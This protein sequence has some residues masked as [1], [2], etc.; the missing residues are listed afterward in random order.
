MLQNAP[1]SV[2]RF[3]QIL[4]KQAG[5]QE[6]GKHRSRKIGCPHDAGREKITGNQ[7]QTLTTSIAR[8]LVLRTNCRLLFADTQVIN[9]TEANQRQEAVEAEERAADRIPV[10]IMTPSLSREDRYCRLTESGRQQLLLSTHIRINKIQGY[11]NN[12]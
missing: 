6:D 12:C 8:R 3:H 4:R 11:R 1:F 10:T 9:D 7:R 5:P 2:T